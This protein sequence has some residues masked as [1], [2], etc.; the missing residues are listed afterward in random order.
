[1]ASSSA[2]ASSG[3]FHT[4]HEHPSIDYSI[5]TFESELGKFCWEVKDL[6]GHLIFKSFKELTHDEIVEGIQDSSGE[7]LWTIHRP[8]RGWYL[9]LRSPMDS[10]PQNFIPLQPKNVTKGKNKRVEFT[11]RLPT[12]SSETT[13]ENPVANG[14]LRK[15]SIDSQIKRRNLSASSSPQSPNRLKPSQDPHPQSPVTDDLIYLQLTEEN[16]RDQTL[17]KSF[18]NLFTNNN[19]KFQCFAKP[20]PATSQLFDINDPI[21]NDDRSILL[22]YKD[23]NSVF[24]IHNNGILKIRFKNSLN[25]KLVEGTDEV[26]QQ[27]FHCAFWVAVC[28]AYLGFRADQDAYIAANEDN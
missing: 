20:S 6:D 7:T 22:D 21:A 3:Q 14:H 27:E 12:S 26:N 5:T 25:F 2:S 17:F 4:G 19:Q 15:D 28:I 10:N 11:F 9:V 24:G 8:I 13:P 1:M 23:Q 16:S 18:T